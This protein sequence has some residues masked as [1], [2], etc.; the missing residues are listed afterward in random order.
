M[1]THIWNRRRIFSLSIHGLIPSRTSVIY[2]AVRRSLK[3]YFCSICRLQK[4]IPRR[5]CMKIFKNCTT[6]W[7]YHDPKFHRVWNESGNSLATYRL[8]FREKLYFS[9]KSNFRVF[10]NYK[11]SLPLWVCMITPKI[12]TTHLP[13]SELQFHQFWKDMSHQLKS[14][15]L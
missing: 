3:R 8:K 4:F 7:S 2:D 6:H 9:K 11:N 5:I 1:P 15:G 13:H 14:Y 10:I 12:F